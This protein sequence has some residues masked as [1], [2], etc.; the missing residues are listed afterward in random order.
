MRKGAL[1]DT[2]S[3]LRTTIDVNGK[4]VEAWQQRLEQMYTDG[5]PFGEILGFVRALLAASGPQL[6]GGT[7]FEL[8]Q[9]VVPLATALLDAGMDVDTLLDRMMG[10]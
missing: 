3:L 9:R 8:E 7:T 6:I 5:V 4:P 2:A 10:L 1:M